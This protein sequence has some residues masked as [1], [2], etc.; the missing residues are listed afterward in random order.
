[1]R[2]GLAVRGAILLDSRFW[3]LVPCKR[4]G[5]A[6]HNPDQL[7]PRDDLEL[8][9]PH[10]TGKQLLRHCATSSLCLSGRRTCHAGPTRLDA[11]WVLQT[12]C[13]S[14]PVAR[15][16]PLARQGMLSGSAKQSETDLLIG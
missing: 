16:R 2:G 6:C 12:L 1:M 3:E 4:H 14:L 13:L 8:H 10:S 7:D 5:H 9:S 11:V 15:A